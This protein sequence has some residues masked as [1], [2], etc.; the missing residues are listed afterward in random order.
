MGESNAEVAE[1]ETE[2]VMKQ[3]E[4]E[5]MSHEKSGPCQNKAHE[6]FNTIYGKYGICVAC[7]IKHPIPKKFLK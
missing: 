7:K 6:V 1:K 2:I 3:C 4:C 5:H